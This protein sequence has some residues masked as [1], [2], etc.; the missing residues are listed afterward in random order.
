MTGI[1]LLNIN[2]EHPI[3]K[4]ICK[5]LSEPEKRKLFNI[6]SKNIPLSEISRSGL[7]SKQ[8]EFVD[9]TEVMEDMYNQLRNDGCKDE[10]ILEKMAKCEPFCLSDENLSTLLDFLNKKGIKL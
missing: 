3:I 7:S 2:D 5:K 6:I 8:N 10:V 9:L 4:A 1:F